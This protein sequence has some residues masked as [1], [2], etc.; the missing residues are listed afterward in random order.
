MA[1]FSKSG[2][3]LSRKLKFFLTNSDELKAANIQV[4]PDMNTSSWDGEGIGPTQP[5]YRLPN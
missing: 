3:G 2:I 1:P 5:S 4:A